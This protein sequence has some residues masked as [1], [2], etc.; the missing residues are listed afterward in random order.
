[1]SEGLRCAEGLRSHR[2]LVLHSRT[3]Q[4][5]S[6][7]PSGPLCFIPALHTSEMERLHPTSDALRDASAVKLACKEWWG[8]CN[9]ALPA[10]KVSD[11]PARL[12]STGAPPCQL[13][14]PLTKRALP[15]NS[16]PARLLSLARGGRVQH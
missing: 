8:L 6:L 4:P 1:M 3:Q 14:T 10:L 9:A 7:S 5:T 2:C 16:A 15:T 11:D 12:V 13:H